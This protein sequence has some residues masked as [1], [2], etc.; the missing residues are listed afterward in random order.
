MSN[1][2]TVP[3]LASILM[4]AGVFIRFIIGR[5]RFYRRGAGGLQHY[6]SYPRSLLIGILEWIFGKLSFVMI[7]FG[8]FLLGIH[9]FNQRQAEKHRAV[10][11]T[12]L[13]P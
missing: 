4:I 1:L 10:Q 9:F 7:L 8:L 5:N 11:V 6:S 3:I 13:K 2:D 12:E